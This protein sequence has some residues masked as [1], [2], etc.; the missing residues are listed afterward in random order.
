LGQHALDVIPLPRQR[1]QEENTRDQHFDSV[2][3]QIKYRE[4]QVVEPFRPA[5]PWPATSG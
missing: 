4:L 2:K 1:D 3:Q 5:M